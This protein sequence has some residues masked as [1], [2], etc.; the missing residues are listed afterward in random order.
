MNLIDKSGISIYGDYSKTL[1][2]N[3]KMAKMQGVKL[4]NL[5]LNNESLRGA[6]LAF[7][8]FNGSDFLH[9][10]FSRSNFNNSSFKNACLNHCSFS[11]CDLSEVDFSG[12]DL[13]YCNFF[14]ANLKDANFDEAKLNFVIPN[15]IEIKGV[16]IDELP[17]VWTK[18]RF[19]L[20]C[21]DFSAKELHRALPL[22]RER[23]G[24]KALYCYEYL[25]KNKEF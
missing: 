11:Y 1:M 20:G 13:K 15:G 22:L 10:D 7:L 21:K 5:V 16:F 12:S 24:D 8:N 2:E 6:D 17:A 4:E 3:L 23:Y 18:D 19:F 14:G 9:C 25:K